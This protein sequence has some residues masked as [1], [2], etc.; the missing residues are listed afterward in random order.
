MYPGAIPQGLGELAGPPSDSASQESYIRSKVREF[1]AVGP[2]MFKDWQYAVRL[3]HQATQI[4][5]HTRALRLKTLAARLQRNHERW[6]STITQLDNI[7]WALRNSRLPELGVLPAGLIATVA[8]VAAAMWYTLT[9]Y[10]T[11]SHALKNER[12]AAETRARELA[13]L[14]TGKLSPSQ[15]ATITSSPTPGAG[16]DSVAAQPSLAEGLTGV[17]KAVG[18]GIVVALLAPTVLDA[19]KGSRRRR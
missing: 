10:I 11:D 2:L 16:P 8:I 9:Q 13:L 12:V 19:V 17:A 14:E 18:L 3:Q 5:D 1:R 4:G 7:N 6:A 15:Y